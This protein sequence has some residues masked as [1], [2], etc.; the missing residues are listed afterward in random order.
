VVVS[1]A[2]WL[3][4]AAFQEN[5][6][7][8]ALGAALRRHLRLNFLLANPSASLFFL[9]GETV[10]ADTT[11]FR[12]GDSDLDIAIGG[13]LLFELFVQPRFKLAD[14]ATAKA[15]DVNVVSRAMRFVIVAITAQVKKIEFVNETL[16]LQEIDG[17]VDSDE[18]NF[19]IDFLGAL[20]D[21]VHVK[22]LLGGIHYLEDNPPLPGKPNT[23]LAESVL[24]MTRGLGG[25]NAFTGGN[26]T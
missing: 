16:A 25:I 17:A 6:L 15:R 18:M 14:F 9:G 11:Y 1:P 3:P 12:A 4:L 7:N 19:G 26:A 24:K 13:D 2:K 23:A 8:F 21:L 5:L 20:K 10:V 22:M